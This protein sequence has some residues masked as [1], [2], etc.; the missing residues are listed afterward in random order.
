MRDPAAVHIPRAAFALVMGAA[1]LAALALA[2]L[3]A[4]R[5]GGGPS[6]ARAAL[7]A[8]AAASTLSFAPAI[9]RIPH[10]HWGVAVL[11]SGVARGL[12]ALL[13]AYLVSR[14]SP[15]LAPRPLFLAV[16]AGAILCLVAETAAAVAILAAIERRR[17]DAASSRRDPAHS[18]RA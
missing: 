5:L 13:L 3:L 9:L 15:S 7:L 10:Q 4:G 17:A 1:T 11:L 16:A 6:E 18:D 12:V 8:L 14:A 2:W